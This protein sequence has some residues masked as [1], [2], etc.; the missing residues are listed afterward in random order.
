MDCATSENISTCNNMSFK[1]Q[2]IH[3]GQLMSTNIGLKFFTIVLRVLN[4][5]IHGLHDC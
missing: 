5:K 1:L 3:G 2:V 4:T